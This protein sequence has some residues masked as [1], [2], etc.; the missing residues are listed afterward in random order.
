MRSEKEIIKAEEKYGNAVWLER[1][2]RPELQEIIKEYLKSGDPKK[3]KIALGAIE[4]AKKIHKTYGNDPEFSLDINNFDHYL[5]M[6]GFINGKLSALRW[7]SGCEWDF[8]D[9]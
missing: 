5:Y 7:V 9:T 4:H 1:N 8:L 2:N 3:E 6:S